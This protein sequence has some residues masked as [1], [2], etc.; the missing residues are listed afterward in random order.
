[1]KKLLVASAAAGLMAVAAHAQTAPAEAGTVVHGG[2]FLADLT[3]WAEAAFGTAIAALVTALVYRAMS[4]MGL[5]VSDAQRDQ[6]QAIV[7]N[8][9]NDAAS[10]AQAQL[11]GNAALDIKVRDQIIAD[12]VAYV[13]VHGADT[14]KALGLDPN[15]GQA[16]NAIRARIATAI[17]DP[18][19][20]T[21]PAIT[22]VASV[23]AAK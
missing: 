16:V 8:G 12:A 1:M 10:K 2:A 14:I 18:K 6:L 11:R 3:A 5:Q 19:A 23:V 7:V 20:P 13:Q 22:P 21:D 15:G 4:W 17:A 9:I